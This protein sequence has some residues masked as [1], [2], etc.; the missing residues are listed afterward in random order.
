MGVGCDSKIFGFS[1]T[2]RDQSSVVAIGAFGLTPA[3]S[4]CADHFHGTCTSS[5]LANF[6]SSTPYLF[7]SIAWCDSGLERKAIFGFVWN[8]G[9]G[10][11]SRGLLA[12]SLGGGA[13]VVV[14]PLGWTK[15]ARLLVACGV[16]FH[17]CSSV[18]VF[19]LPSRVCAGS[20]HPSAKTNPLPSRDFGDMIVSSLGLAFA[21]RG[22]RASTSSVT[23]SGGNTTF[24]GCGLIEVSSFKS[25]VGFHFG[26]GSRG[27]SI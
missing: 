10:S 16:A 17:S 26:G 5:F 4:I 15:L 14:E 19:G 1:S 2:V 21:D 23:P 27:G 3:C 13:E 18:M 7:R 25:E 6:S 9:A 12:V 22:E 24:R 20:A 8:W 11:M